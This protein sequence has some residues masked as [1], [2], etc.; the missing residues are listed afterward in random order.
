MLVYGIAAV[1]SLAGLRLVSRASEL[2]D[3]ILTFVV[4]AV[5]LGLPIVA[6]VLW[7]VA[8]RR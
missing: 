7:F 2:P 3:W 5:F 6:V 1:L 4:L 8:H